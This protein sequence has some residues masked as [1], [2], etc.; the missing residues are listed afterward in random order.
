M[1]GTPADLSLACAWKHFGSPARNEVRKVLDDADEMLGEMYPRLAY[2]VE[3]HMFAFR[4]EDYRDM[5]IRMTG[6][7]PRERGQSPGFRP[8]AWLRRLLLPFHREA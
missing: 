5:L 2:F 8:F 1:D 3:T 7:G 6:C 4:Q